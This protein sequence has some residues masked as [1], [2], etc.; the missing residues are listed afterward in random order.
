MLRSGELYQIRRRHIT[1]Y[2]KH[3]GIALVDTKTSKRTG[4]Q[5]MLV[6]ESSE[7]NK[8]LRLACRKKSP[9]ALLLSGGSPRFR[10]I[11]KSLIDLFDVQ[12]YLSV[13]SLR[14]GGAS[15]DFLLHGSMERT[16]L[17]GRWSSPTTA[18]IYVQDAVATV[19]HLRLSVAAKQMAVTAAGVL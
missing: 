1:F 12:G 9:S 3:S 8:Y 2:D 11:F 4:A 17:R 19:S 10:H 18:R 16:L 13:Y 15:W 5:E 14:R 7:A 6:I